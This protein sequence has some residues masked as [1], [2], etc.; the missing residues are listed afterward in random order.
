[1]TQ[2]YPCSPAA[3]VRSFVRHRPLIAQLVRREVEGRYRGSMLGML[4]SL[5]TP[6]LMLAI[7]T[8]VFTVVFKA[9]WGV[10]DN[11]DKAEF[12]VVLFSGIMLHAF[13]AEC[14]TRAPMLVLE[15]VNLVKKVVFPLEI[16]AFT[17]VGSALF[18]LVMSFAVLLVGCLLVLHDLPTTVFYAPL[19][20]APFALLMLGL[21]WGLAS[22]GVYLRDIGQIVAP[23]MAVFMFL[24]PV[25]Y[26][27][28][29]LPAWAATLVLW[30]NPL[31]LIVMQLREVVIWG[32][33]PDFAALGVYTLVAA[34]VAALGFAWFQKTR[35]GFADVL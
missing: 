6:L 20:V 27:L 8:F 16:H 30:L 9:R 5:V 22:L 21:V 26:S 14:L 11:G 33:A 17:L 2:H 29:L 4:W 31:S 24:S 18:H 19:V 13:L 3:A 10:G 12:A 1:M 23:M 32:H 7:Y 28:D 35:K 34:G 15:N 25:F